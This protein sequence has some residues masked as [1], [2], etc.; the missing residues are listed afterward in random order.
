[1]EVLEQKLGVFTAQQSKFKH[2]R[3]RLLEKF[4]SMKQTEEEAQKDEEEIQDEMQLIDAKIK[5]I[6]DFNS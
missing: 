3:D 5:D 2:E 6:N 1:M 4:Y